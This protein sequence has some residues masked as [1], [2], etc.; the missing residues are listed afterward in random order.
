MGLG[1]ATYMIIRALRNF[2]R[3]F[4]RINGY[5]RRNVFNEK[6]SDT[7]IQKRKIVF[8]PKF[9]KSSMVLIHPKTEHHVFQHIHLPT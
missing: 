9:L 6:K 4:D 8:D 7:N 1:N 3:L 5:L 2:T